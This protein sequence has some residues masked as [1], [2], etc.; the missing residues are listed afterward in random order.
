MLTE[1]NLEQINKQGITEKDIENQLRR[2]EQGFPPLELVDAA[3]PANGIKILSDDEE[4]RHVS[5]FENALSSGLNATKFVPASGA[6]SR[7]F[8][9]LYNYLEDGKETD[10][11]RKFAD[12]IEKFAFFEELNA[13]TTEKTTHKFVENLLSEEGLNYGNLPKGLLAF[14][15]YNGKTRTPFEEHLVEAAAYCAGSK[16][17]ANVHFTISPEHKKGFEKLIE[18]VVPVYQKRFGIK[19]NI[20]F[21][22]QHKNTDTIA[23]DLNNKPFKD[24]N[25]DLVFRPGGHGALI[26]NLNEL[27]S[28]IIFIKNIDNVVPDKLKHYNNR[29]KKALAGLMVSIRNKT[30]EYLEKL[31][32]TESESNPK[33][34]KNVEDFIKKE[35]HV[36]YEQTF[37]STSDKIHF[38]KTILNRPIRICG[39]VKNQGEPGGG[40]FLTK[41]PDGTVSLQ[42]VEKAQIDMDN[43]QQVQ[44]IDKSTHFNPVDIIC[45]TKNY[46]GQKFDLSQYT[47]PNT[48]FISIKSKNGDEMKALELPGLWNG[49]MSNWNT[50]FVEVPVETFNP[51]KTVNDLLRP[52]HQKS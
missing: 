1:K 26:K 52:E 15:K 20:S 27:D 49:A 8:K 32:K 2:F 44:L 21:S 6:A 18:N 39:M 45:S 14:H 40:P 30:F 37:E 28:D 22:V 25:E 50:V 19:F 7:M 35:L 34:I 38:L 3:T 16:G 33:L 47:D 46:K 9:D 17:K 51:V 31:N 43:T 11:I 48:G 36:H 12:N 10:F 23:V 41:N 24:E 13:I 29:Y 5:I 42:I 4:E